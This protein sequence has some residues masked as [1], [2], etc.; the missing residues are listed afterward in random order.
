MTDPSRPAL[1]AGIGTAVAVVR[2]G[3]VLLGRR[4]GSYG[5]GLWQTPGGKPDPGETL[6]EA[7]VRET[8]E[9]TGLAVGDPFEI[10]RQFDD[11]AEIGYRYETVFFAVRAPFGEPENT[12]PD[13]CHGWEWVPLDALPPAAERFAIDDATV[14]AIRA[15]ERQTA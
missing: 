12:E 14:E 2:D 8:L 11:F 9:E 6:L 7:A 3:A 13:K 15:F 1:R 5:D 4:R 10:A